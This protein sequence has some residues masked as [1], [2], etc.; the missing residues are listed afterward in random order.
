MYKLV[1][2]YAIPRKAHAIVGS[3]TFNTF[4]RATDSTHMMNNAQVTTQH[5]LRP[6]I[7]L[8]QEY[9]DMYRPLSP[10]LIESGKQQPYD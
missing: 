8:N 6:S 1:S 7:V 3:N 9:T 10:Q 5:S 4:V 2:L